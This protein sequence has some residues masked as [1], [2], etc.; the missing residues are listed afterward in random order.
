MDA[1]AGTIG[2]SP[3]PSTARWPLTDL[4]LAAI[5]AAVLAWGWRDRHDQ[6]LDPHAWPG[7]LLGLGGSLAMLLVLGFS[8]RK[9]APAGRVSV[10]WWY[11][12]H[13]VLGLFGAAAV[14]IHARFAWGSINSSFALAATLL[15]VAS[16]LIARYLVAPA[17]RSANRWCLWLV[18]T[19]HYL[20]VPLYMVLVLAVIVHVYMAHAY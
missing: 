19:W 4:A 8:V 9:R 10:G 18:E 12:A 11:N 5:V 13:I 20:H 7:Y 6:A 3:A 1:M 16:G 15:V 2:Q 17:R 14:V